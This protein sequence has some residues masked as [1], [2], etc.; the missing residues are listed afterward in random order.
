MDEWGL[1]GENAPAPDAVFNINPDPD[2][3]S[4]VNLE[5]DDWRLVSLV[6]GIRNVEEIVNRSGL[7]RL[8]ALQIISRLVEKRIIVTNRTGPGPEKSWDLVAD[9]FHPPAPPNRGLLGR[10]IDRLR[11][12]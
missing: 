4:T 1:V 2:V 8:A 9:S 5:I 3:A 10:I 12:L 11:G 7:S 6:N